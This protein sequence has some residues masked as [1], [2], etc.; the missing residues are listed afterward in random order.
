MKLL[1]AALLA[2]CPFVSQGTAPQGGPAV[3]ASV[4][5]YCDFDASKTEA[6]EVECPENSTMDAACLEMKTEEYKNDVAAAYATACGQYNVAYQAYK[7][8]IKT[9][10]YDYQQ[11]FLAATTLLQIEACRDTFIADLEALNKGFND[12]AKLIQESLDAELSSL[13]SGF[14]SSVLTDCCMSNR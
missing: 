12:L 10:L 6:P 13:S 3:P 5:P 1:I 8:G 11:C 4:N 9:A 7:I 14:V 2:M